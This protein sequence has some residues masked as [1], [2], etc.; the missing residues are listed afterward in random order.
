MS[1]TTGSELVVREEESLEKFAPG[2]T[3]RS[4]WNFSTD[5]CRQDMMSKGYAVEVQETMLALF[6]WC[7]DPR[8]PVR[9]SDAATA[10]GCS[11]NLI[12]QLLRGIYEKPP[13]QLMSKIRTWLANEQ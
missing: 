13:A 1:E 5:Q 4:S 2:D 11:Q 8:H 12:Y 9:R 10:L 7:I 6:L 3:V